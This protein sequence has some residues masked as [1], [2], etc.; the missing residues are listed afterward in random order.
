V[1]VLVTHHPF[2]LP[3]SYNRGDLVGRAHQAMIQIAR[4]GIDLLLAGHFHLSHAGRTALRYQIPGHSAIFVQA[5]TM[6]TRVRGEENAF[7]VIHA[8]RSEIAVERYAC[9]GGDEFRRMS[10]DLFRCTADGWAD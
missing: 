10:T 8:D 6:S 1:K 7:N 9:D 4:C 3:E 5:G 2:D